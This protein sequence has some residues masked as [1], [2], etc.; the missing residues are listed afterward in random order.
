[1]RRGRRGPGRCRPHIGPHLLAGAVRTTTP[2]H[3]F[4]LPSRNPLD[5]PPRLPYLPLP[6]RCPGP[7]FPANKSR[8]QTSTFCF[9]ATRK[10]ARKKTLDSGTKSRETGNPPLDGTGSLKTEQR[11]TREGGRKSSPHGGL[12]DSFEGLVRRDEPGSTGR[13]PAGLHG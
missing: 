6:R 8:R 11:R 9:A 1:L 7:I 2:A 10:A 12:R 5:I 4:R 13:W 3:L